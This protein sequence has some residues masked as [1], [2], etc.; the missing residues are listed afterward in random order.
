MG[1]LEEAI[2]LRSEGQLEKSN[3]LLSKLVVE[4]PEDALVNY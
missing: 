2:Q 4:C 3:V 1:K